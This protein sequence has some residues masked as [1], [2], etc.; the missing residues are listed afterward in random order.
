MADPRVKKLAEI[1]VNYSIKIKKGDLIELNFGIDAK[2]LVLEVYKLILKKR[3]YPIVHAG[4]QGFTYTYYKNASQEQLARFPKLAMIEAKMAH[5]SIN[6]GAAYNTK[7]LTRIN[8]KKIAIRRK[9]TKR[10]H[11]EYIKKDNWVICEFPTNSLAQ[12]AE[13]SLEEFEDF[14]YTATNQDWKKESKKQIKLKK[15]LDKGKQVRITAE[16]TDLTFSIKGR[17]SIM[18]DGHRNMPDGE[19]FI[20]PVENSTE[21][22]I[23]Y[24]YPAIRG[25]REVSGIFLRFHKGKVVEVK[26]EKGE[27]FLKEMI[28]TD[29][30][31]SKLGEFGIGVNYNIK[32]FIKQILFDEKI[33]GTVHLAL[34]MA[35]PQGGGRNKSAVHWDMIKDLRRGGKL[36]IDGKLIQK[37]G[38]FTFKL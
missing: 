4:V 1:L 36:F 34:G 8:P 21:G 3:A 18:C 6:V 27:A 13:M 19:V 17:E 24:T 32:Q 37:N 25:G 15:T 20:A 9:I 28:K 2:E 7:E 10:I 22:Y 16:D 14:V 38:K 12:D 33:G 31:S 35:Y 26:A 29:K 30:G 23:K 5:G 11:D